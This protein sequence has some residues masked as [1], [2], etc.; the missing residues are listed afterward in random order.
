MDFGLTGKLVAVT[1]STSGIGRAIALQFVRARARVAINGRTLESCEKAKAWIAEQA[2]ADLA[3]VVATIVCIPANVATKEGC[4]EFEAAVAAIGVPLY[5]LI[6]NMGIFHVEPFDDISD[7]KWQEYYDTNTMSGVRLARAFLKG[8]LARNEGRIVFIAS[9]TGVRP[10]PHMVAYSVSKASQINLARGLAELTK[11]TNVTVNSVLP[12]P[13]M[14]DGVEKYMEDF[15]KAHGFADRE[16]AVKA[17]F[18]RHETTS[19]LQRF[20]QPEE[21]ANVVVFI[22]SALGSAVNGAAQLAEGGLI[23]HI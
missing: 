3:E 11:G 2:G 12:G 6:N 9:E 4:A 8:M 20:L 21:V 19:L 16:S 15:A 1:G 7:E 23:R 17:Y 10:L 18:E 5:G 13:T 22:A 14:T